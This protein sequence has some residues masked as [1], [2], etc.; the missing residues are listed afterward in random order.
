[1][2]RIERTLRRLLQGPARNARFSAT[3]QRAAYL[4]AQWLARA[5]YIANLVVVFALASRTFNE[6][7]ESPLT[8][9]LWP[10]FWA[11]WIDP[12][13]GARVLVLALLAAAV[14]CAVIPTSRA[15]RVT[16]AILFLEMV[17]LRLS[18]GY[19]VHNYHIWLWLLV[20]FSVFPIDR[21]WHI[22]FGERPALRHRTL[23]MFFFIQVTVGLFYSLSGLWKFLRGFVIPPGYMSTFSPDALA[24]LVTERWLINEHETVLQPF[25]LANPWIGLPAQLFVVYVELFTLVAVFRPAMH[26]PFGV[27]LITF[28]LMVWLLMGIQFL[29]QPMMLALVLVFSPFAATASWRSS[30]RQIPL[31]G[32][33]ALLPQTLAHLRRPRHSLGRA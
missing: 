13:L 4:N 11:R 18:T 14:A 9:P 32:D 12:M 1:M 25:F 29:F 7:L 20:L 22:H 2:H 8:E 33:L 30:L 26:R 17:A 6:V 23:S 28:H 19:F 15:A 10:V 16:L 5:V 3:E 31:F 27:A 24:A 21:D